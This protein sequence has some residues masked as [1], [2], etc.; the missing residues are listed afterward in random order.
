MKL[1]NLLV[2]SFVFLLSSSAV[3]AVVLGGANFRDALLAFPFNTQMEIETDFTCSADPDDVLAGDPTDLCSG[4]ARVC[5]GTVVT[6]TPRVSLA[7]WGMTSLD[8][9]AYYPT[10][11]GAT[12][13]DEM[14]PYATFTSNRNMEWLDQA[15]FDSLH[16]VGENDAWSAAEH[17]YE[18]LGR[19]YN[20]PITFSSFLTEYSDMR[21]GANV[22][23]GG[24][25]QVLWERG[26]VGT[27]YGDSPLV[28][29]G[30]VTAASVDVTLSG[31]PGTDLIMTRLY[32][33]DCFGSV[34]AHPIDLADDPPFLMVSFY[35]DAPSIPEARTSRSIEVS[36]GMCSAVRGR[37]EVIGDLTAAG[38]IGFLNMTLRNTGDVDIVA[39]DA[40]STTAGFEAM[41]LDPA[42]CA[43]F[44]MVCDN[45]F[46][47]TIEPSEEQ[48]LLIFLR[49]NDGVTDCPDL[50]IDYDCEAGGC[51]GPGSGSYC[52]NLCDE[53]LLDC[54]I[55]PDSADMEVGD[56]ED[57]DVYCE[58]DGVPVDPDDADWDTD[59]VVGTLD[60]R[61][62]DGATF[63]AGDDSTGEISVDVTVGGFTD[64]ATAPITI[65]E[66]DDTPG[67]EE[68]ETQ[69]CTITPGR[70]AGPTGSVGRF[71]V[72]CGPPED[73]ERCVEGAVEWS[74]NDDTVVDLIEIPH[75]DHVS[76]RARIIGEEGDSAWVRA[77][78]GGEEGHFCTAVVDVTPPDC[79]EYS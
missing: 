6:V 19:F 64:T 31:S 44:G 38:S 2:L 24:N 62:T 61:G 56:S 41:P 52:F 67:D 48:E 30:A 40:R 1:N 50:C 49:N 78:I 4:G 60:D 51:G 5:P 35:T 57:F 74:T 68:S 76:R 54:W 22:F 72:R 10:S 45:G 70:Y 59:G 29:T 26:G 28:G 27:A 23:C 79:V 43:M 25:I 15:T 69:Y 71:T 9:I 3:N 11:C 34:V 75:L 17:H 7:R 53:G 63:T 65:G 55:V 21:G 14:I 18:A 12:C 20:Q 16:W 33:H 47:H 66:G 73:V 39:D 13:P 42:L 36:G 32:E 77:T 8:A 58:L 37:A 46:G